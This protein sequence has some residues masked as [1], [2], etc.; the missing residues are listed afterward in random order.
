MS[1]K[2]AL[3]DWDQS[4][5]E[6]R[7]DYLEATLNSEI[8]NRISAVSD[9]SV[10]L[11]SEIGS[12]S[13]RLSGELSAHSD[14]IL[15]NRTDIDFLL[16]AERKSM[17]YLGTLLSVN[18]HE[19]KDL[20]CY[21]E[22]ALGFHTEPSFK[23]KQGFTFR[24]SA[25]QTDLYG[26][27]DVRISFHPSDVLTFN[28]DTE[29]S[30]V[31]A[32]DI[33][34]INDYN[35]ELYDLSTALSG[36]I[37]SLST[38]LSGEIGSLSTALSGEIGSLST[39]LS[40]EI[41]SLSTALSGEID[42]LSAKLSGEIKSLSSAL[43]G[44]IKSLSS[45]LSS[46]IK[47]LSS[48]LSGEIKELSAALSGEIGSLSTRLSGEIGSLSTALSGEIGSLSVK[49]SGE[50]GNLKDLVSRTIDDPGNSK[51]GVVKMVDE[52]PYDGEFGLRNY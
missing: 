42:T 44:E 4:M 52:H 35:T 5:Q 29:L 38:A 14:Q 48:A 40:G 33:D 45:A 28:R 18:D 43:S 41:G 32:G 27:D 10:R 46:E 50:V 7:L 49:L 25:E 17:V 13:T 15:S 9:L 6:S 2:F 8:S 11:S 30:A 34:V 47:S 12:L 36:E 22:N 3:L 21:F 37:G 1:G 24:I 51:P 26:S 23:F 19:D 39:R 20:S 31:C 16:Y